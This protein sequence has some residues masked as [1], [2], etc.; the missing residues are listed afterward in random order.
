MLF[1]F[2]LLLPCS[3]LIIFYFKHPSNGLVVELDNMVKLAEKC[4]IQVP[5]EVV[6]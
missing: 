5:M 3:K 4:N 6:K 2:V 1:F